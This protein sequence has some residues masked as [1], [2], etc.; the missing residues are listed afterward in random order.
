[1][2]ASLGPVLANIFTTELERTVIEKLINDGTIKFYSRYVDDTLVL[3][4]PEDIDRVHVALNCFDENIKFT[5]DKFVDEIPHFLDIEISPDGLSIY[6]KETQ[7]GQYS[8]YNS[9]MP[10]KWKTAWISSLV[11]RAKSICSANILPIELSRIRKYISW[12]GF[13]KHIG[14]KIINNTLAKQSNPSSLNQHEKVNH[15][16]IYFNLPYAGQKGEQLVKSCIRKVKKCL[17]K[18]IPIHFKIIYKTHNMSYYVNNKDHT[19]LMQ[20]S[21]VIYEFSCPGCHANYIGKTERTLNERSQEHGWTNKDKP[22]YHHLMNCENF[23]Y[24][25][26][27]HRC[28]DLLEN[29]HT[30]ITTTDYDL[31]IRN[32]LINTVKT[33]IKVLDRAAHWDI[34]L[35]KEGLYIKNLNPTLNNGFQYTYQPHL[36]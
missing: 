21:N 35:I 29:S 1:M 19:P 33:N 26:N 12:N 30:S 20:Q 36:F 24:I 3:L 13:P 5:V 32:F 16:T 31:D 18:D 25:M 17:K 8:H 2:G 14:N 6:H 22:V 10:W 15:K 11:Y 4:K 27:I 34:L 28:N 23:Q 7:T 9:N